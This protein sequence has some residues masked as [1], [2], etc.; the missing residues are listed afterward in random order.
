DLN[1]LDLS[2]YDGIISTVNLDIDRPFLT[3]NPLLPD[4]DIGY[5]SS[6]L[7]TKETHHLVTHKEVETLSTSKDDILETM[8]A[9]LKLV[10]SVKI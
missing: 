1:V 9:G 5:V 10:D 4:S 2:S 7:N 8:R 3:V 6:F